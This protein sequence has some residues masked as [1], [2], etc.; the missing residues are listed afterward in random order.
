MLNAIES[1]APWPT[2]LLKARAAVM[3]KDG[4]G[5]FTSLGYRLITVLPA[6]YRRWSG[7]R[8]KHLEE[9]VLSWAFPEMYAGVPSKGA[10]QAWWETAWRAEQARAHG[11][12]WALACVDCYKCF[13]Q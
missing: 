4:G 10:A 13:D 1:G 3:E 2:S 5:A 12:D 9:W 6:I 7:I 8:L 11:H